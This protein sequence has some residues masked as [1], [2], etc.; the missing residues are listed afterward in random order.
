MAGTFR[1]CPLAERTKHRRKPTYS[2]AVERSAPPDA[3]LHLRVQPRTVAGPCEEMMKP[4][5]YGLSSN[6]QAI[7]MEAITN[8]AVGGNNYE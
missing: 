5:A 3:A 4:C 8:I 6:G 7:I 1:L 2:H